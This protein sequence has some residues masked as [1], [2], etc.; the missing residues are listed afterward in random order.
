MVEITDTGWKTLGVNKLLLVSPIT[1][2]LSCNLSRRQNYILLFV[3]ILIVSRT[4][5]ALLEA[6]SLF[7]GKSAISKER[8]QRNRVEGALDSLNIL[9]L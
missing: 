3:A 1:T 6:C 2:I 4:L 5:L 7:E 8:E 9:K